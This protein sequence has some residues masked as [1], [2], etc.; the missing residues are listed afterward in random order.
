MR[1]GF[2]QKLYRAHVWKLSAQALVMLRGRGEPYSV[3]FGPIV[4]VPEKK[5]DLV[6]DVDGETSEHPSSNGRQGCERFEHEF[7]WGSRV[8]LAREEAPV[9]RTPRGAGARSKLLR[10]E[11]GPSHVNAPSA[12]GSP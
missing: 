6:I 11:C 5:Y 9:N 4:M 3:V 8:P 12:S 2:P 10:A 1:D 7:M